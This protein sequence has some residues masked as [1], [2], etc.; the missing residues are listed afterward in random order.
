ME[1]PRAPI[2][3]DLVTAE[4]TQWHR[5][6]TWGRQAEICA[7]YLKKGNTVYV[8]GSIRSHQYEDKTGQNRTSFEIQSENVVFLGGRKPET[9]ESEAPV[10]SAVVEVV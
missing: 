4:E 5:I 6:V 10:H 8:E 3:Q 2:A 1:T 9:N 7:Q